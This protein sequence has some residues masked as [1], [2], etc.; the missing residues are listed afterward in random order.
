MYV[1]GSARLNGSPIADPA[2][3]RGPHLTFNI[4]TLAASAD[5]KLS[6]RVLVGAGTAMGANLNHAVAVSGTSQSNTA[7]ARVL[8]QGGILSD[9]GFIVGKVF[10][11]CNGNR[12]QDRGEM[13]IPGI[14]I[15]LDDGTFAITDSEGRYSIYGVPGRTHILKVDMYSLPA[16]TQFSA[17]SSRNAGDGGSRFID[18]KFGEMQKAD[19]AISNCT[20]ASVEDIKQRRQALGPQEEL[21]RAVKAQFNTQEVAKDPLQLKSMAASGLVD[22]SSAATAAHTN[23]LPAAATST[24]DGLAV[25]SGF[26]ESAGADMAFVCAVT[27]ALDK[28]E[29]ESIRPLADID[30][31]CSGSLA[32]SCVLNCAFTARASS[33]C[34]PSF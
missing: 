27:G 31:N 2:G 15:Y 14:R 29:D 20:S 25:A 19:F 30:F 22:S 6:Y 16:N 3:G 5:V 24:A 8:V 1:K 13:G 33:S 21:A 34:E 7:S 23:P 17:I 4:G 32:I 11:D 10:Q 18:L 12:M 26:T 9:N 28:D